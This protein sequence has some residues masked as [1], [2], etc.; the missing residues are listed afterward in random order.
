MEKVDSRHR[1]CLSNISRL[2]IR[3]QIQICLIAK[4][5]QCSIVYMNMHGVYTRALARY[6]QIYK[7]NK[8]KAMN[9]IL[10]E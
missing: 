1:P 7:H 10:I 6:T 4:W 5:V 3:R 2:D 8:H 9:W